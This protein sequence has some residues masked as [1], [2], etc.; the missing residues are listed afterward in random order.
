M[1]IG[2]L[3]DGVLLFASMIS[4]TFLGSCDKG[5]G[6]DE[7]KDLEKYV[8][9]G[10]SVKWATFN[11]GAT[12]PEEYGYYFAWGETQP[13]SDY[14][15]DTYKYCNKPDATIT[16]YCD[17][18]MFG[19]KGFTDNKIVLDAED[20]AA[21]VNWGGDWRMPTV[22]EFEEL[23]DSVNCTWTWTAV[24][25]VNG[26]KVVSKISGYEGNYIFL[27]ATGFRSE[28]DLKFDGSYG[29]YWSTSL[30]TNLPS[31]AIFLEFSVF[32]YSIDQALRIHGQT[33]RPVCK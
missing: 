1:K 33:V 31:D 10:L 9:L 20:D 26:Y 5:I 32:R 13:K 25:G 3:F 7:K 4:M 11:I 23:M 6:E 29:L 28:K 8:D 12:K 17:Y 24:N 16:K 15:W 18:S 22:S 19:Y 30:G 21:H 14:S 2:K 27:P